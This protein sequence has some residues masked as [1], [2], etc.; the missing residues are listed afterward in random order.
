MSDS[1]KSFIEAEQE[2]G[3][4]SLKPMKQRVGF[5]VTVCLFVCGALLLLV[6]L[7]GVLA[8]VSCG[9][10]GGGSGDGSVLD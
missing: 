5:Y 4:A 10:G 7:V 6:T 9:G 2:K 3:E 1:K 8:L